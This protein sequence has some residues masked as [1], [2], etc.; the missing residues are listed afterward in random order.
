MAH[1]RSKISKLQYIYTR[2]NFFFTYHFWTYIALCTGTVGTY[3]EEK[4]GGDDIF[5][6][7][8]ICHQH[9]KDIHRDFFGMCAHLYNSQHNTYYSVHNYCSTCSTVNMINHLAVLRTF[10]RFC[11]GGHLCIVDACKIAIRVHSTEVKS[12]N[13]SALGW[14][15]KRN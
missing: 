15:K 14:R 11:L 4:R 12:I 13:Q 7:K 9:T 8:A 6:G 2:G 3:G 1:K 5:F 10:L